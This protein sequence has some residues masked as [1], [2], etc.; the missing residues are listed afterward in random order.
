MENVDYKKIAELLE[1]E[2]GRPVNP[3][4][5]EDALFL[6]RMS[7]EQGC[8]LSVADELGRLP[9]PRMSEAMKAQLMVGAPE[10]ELRL[11]AAG[12]LRLATLSSRVIVHACY[13]HL[14]G[15][16]FDRRIKGNGGT[17]P[18]MASGNGIVH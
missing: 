4:S 10:K 15:D 7:E 12:M 5:V 18:G 14:C 16:L 8:F 6:L 2:V 11:Y 9:M 17:Y 13:R 3:G 1:A